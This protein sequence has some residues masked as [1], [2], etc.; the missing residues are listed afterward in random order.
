MAEPWHPGET[1]EEQAARRAAYQRLVDAAR[2]VGV[3]LERLAR[4]IE[5]VARNETETRRFL[6]DEVYGVPDD[7]LDDLVR[8]RLNVLRGRDT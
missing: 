7:L 4:A 8:V 3:P 6:S 1:P 5:K 2:R